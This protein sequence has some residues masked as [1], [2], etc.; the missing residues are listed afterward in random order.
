MEKLNVDTYLLKLQYTV[1]LPAELE[2]MIELS[3]LLHEDIL[4]NFQ[5]YRSSSYSGQQQPFYP[6]TN[7][8]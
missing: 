4:L 2:L 1:C 5:L 3:Y 6:T 8:P 7:R